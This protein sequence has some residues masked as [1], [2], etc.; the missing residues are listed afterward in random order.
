VTKS[1]NHFRLLLIALAAT[2]P[3][4]HYGL[5]RQAGSDVPSV[6]RTWDDAAIATLEVPLADPIG[7][8]KHITADY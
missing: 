1:R 4:V 3:A 2:L 7:S 6:P 8:P 5:A